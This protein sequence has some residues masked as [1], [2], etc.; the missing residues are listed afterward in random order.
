MAGGRIE[1]LGSSI[2]AAWSALQGWSSQ[3]VEWCTF[4]E[5]QFGGPLSVTTTAEVS[6]PIVAISGTTFDENK[7]IFVLIVMLSIPLVA[8]PAPPNLIRFSLFENGV[9]I[10]VIAALG[11]AA[12][13]APQ[14]PVSAFYAKILPT[15]DNAP[16]SYTYDVRA[17]VDGGTGLVYGNH[18]GPATYT[19]IQLGVLALPG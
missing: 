9:S 19:M 18:G 6:A 17:W 15:G 14:A 12:G 5:T 2:E 13:S 10:G 16:L 3:V 8:A 11:A 1:G 4:S 7:Q